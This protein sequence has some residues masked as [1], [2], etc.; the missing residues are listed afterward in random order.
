MPEKLIGHIT[1][2]FSN[3]NVGV[4]ELTEGELKAGDKIHVK[5]HTTDFEQTVDSLQ[6]DNEPV[7]K[8]GVG[9]SAGLK[10]ADHAREHDEVYLVTEE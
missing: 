3:L 10:V 7:E 6:V 5:G 8:I 9:E 1:H 2:Y 4:I